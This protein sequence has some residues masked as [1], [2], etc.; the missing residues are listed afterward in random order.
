MKYRFA[1]FLSLLF[2]PV[3]FFF[4]MPFFVVY[5]QTASPWSAMKWMLFSSLFIDIGI[6]LL[7]LG[8]WRGIFSDLDIS[9][10]E[11]RTTFYLFALLLALLYLIA[12]LFFK[13]ILFPLSLVALGILCGIPLFFLMNRYVK[14]SIHVG[15]ATS[16]I[17][18]MVVMYGNMLFFFLWWIYPCVVW[19][20]LVLKKH[21][22][23]EVIA[24]TFLGGA[25]TGITLL[26]GVVF[27]RL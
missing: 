6:V 18:T 2:H 12:A 23:P 7:L 9:K 3:V 13:G 20:R 24:G 8:R 22:I 4:V 1:E 16:F 15:I 17:I 26:L 27:Y 21:T 25:I 11:E 14:A 10:R 19:S 5:R